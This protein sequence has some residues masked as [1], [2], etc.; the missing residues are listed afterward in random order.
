MTEWFVIDTRSNSIVNCVTANVR[1][2][3]VLARF[4]D[5]E[6]LRLDPNPPLEMLRRYRYWDER[7]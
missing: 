4:T 3:G 1:P 5:A 2:D 6:H 7:P